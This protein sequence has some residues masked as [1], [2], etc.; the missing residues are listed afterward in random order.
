MDVQASHEGK[1]LPSRSQGQL[2]TIDSREYA[3]KLVVES[4]LATKMLYNEVGVP[5]FN[6]ECR[7]NLALAVVIV[8]RQPLCELWDGYVAFEKKFVEG[9]SAPDSEVYETQRSGTVA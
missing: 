2:L 5:L 9:E 8:R 4:L 7:F 6:H 1:K 3:L